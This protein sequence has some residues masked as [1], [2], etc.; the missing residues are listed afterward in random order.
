MKLKVHWQLCQRMTSAANTNG[1]DFFIYVLKHCLQI[2]TIEADA[3]G[4]AEI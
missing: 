2:D 4:W 1:N 3:L